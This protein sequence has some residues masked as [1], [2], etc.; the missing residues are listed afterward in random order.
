MFD[1]KTKVTRAKV[2]W[3]LDVKFIELI[4]YPTWLAII[5]MAKNKNGK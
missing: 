2:K 1:E 4:D 3:L 5:V